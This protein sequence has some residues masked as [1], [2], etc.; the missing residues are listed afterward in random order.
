MKQRQSGVTLIE[1]LMAIAILAII[2]SI[3][4]PLYS[5]YIST[6]RNTEGRNNLA[7]IRLVQEEYFLENNRY[8]PNPDGTAS[9]TAANLSTYWTP[10]EPD[11]DRNFNYTVVSSSSGTTYTATATGR[12]GTYKVPSTETFSITE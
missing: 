10:A 3:A 8:F 6:A 4:I 9:T 7:S 12:G 11:A 5:G 1:L 2:A